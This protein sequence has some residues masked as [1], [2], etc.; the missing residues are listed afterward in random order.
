[1]DVLPLKKKNFKV[2]NSAFNKIEK[3][4]FKM[5]CSPSFSMHLK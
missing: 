5:V 1:M 2:Y 4:E 3:K